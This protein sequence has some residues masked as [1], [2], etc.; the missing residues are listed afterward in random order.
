MHRQKGNEWNWTMREVIHKP[1]RNKKCLFCRPFFHIITFYGI[2]LLYE[3]P[4]NPNLPY[5]SFLA[6]WLEYLLLLVI[7]VPNMDGIVIT[8]EKKVKSAKSI[9]ITLIYNLYFE[10]QFS[11]AFCWCIICCIYVRSKLNDSNVL[12][13]YIL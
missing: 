6:L 9:Y 12:L 13:Q 10:M 3:Q 8:F 2:F 11:F 4:F 1:Q 5:F 7:L